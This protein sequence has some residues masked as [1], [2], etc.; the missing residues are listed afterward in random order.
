MMCHSHVFNQVLEERSISQET[1]GIT[2]IQI[3]G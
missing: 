1:L 3:M 2:E